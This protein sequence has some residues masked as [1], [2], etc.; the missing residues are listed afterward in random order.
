MLAIQRL[1][2]QFKEQFHLG[3][4]VLALDPL[5]LEQIDMIT[6]LPQTKQGFKDFHAALIEP[7]LFNHIADSLAGI[8]QQL[9]VDLV[10]ILRQFAGSRSLDFRRKILGHLLLEPSQQEGMQLAAQV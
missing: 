2:E 10:L 7:F 6:G 9:H 8:F 5:K 4:R 1:V 3:R